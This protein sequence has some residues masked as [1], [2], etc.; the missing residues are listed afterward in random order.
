MEKSYKGYLISDDKDRLSSEVI[1]RYL[2]HQ[3]YWA[4]G[5]SIETVERSL[6]QSLCIGLYDHQDDQVGFARIITDYSTTYYICDLF[7][8]PEHRGKSLGKRL[9]E[10]IVDHPSLKGLSGMLLTMD[11]HGLYRRFGFDDSEGTQKRFMLR[12]A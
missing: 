4:Q 6:E 12:K 8:L 7:I 5:R 3:S 11:A 9:V 10:F 2:C 1:Q